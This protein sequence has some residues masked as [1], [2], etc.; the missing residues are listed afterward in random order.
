MTSQDWHLRLQLSRVLLTIGCIAAAVCAQTRGPDTQST[1]LNQGETIQRQLA[2]GQSHEYYFILQAGQYTRLAV[3]QR[4]INVAVAVFASDG[5]E[6]FVTD[7]YGIGAAEPVELIADI[8][9]IYRFR[10][11]ASER[12]APIGRYEL[13]LSEVETATDRHKSRVAATRAVAQAWMFSA[14]QTREGLLK[15]V[16]NLEMGLVNWQAAGDLFEQARTMYSIGLMYTVIGDQQKALDYT[17]RALPVARVSHDARAEAWALDSIGLVY[18]RF[19]DKRKAVEYYD[20]ALLLMRATKDRAGE[21][22]TLNHLGAAYLR[23]GEK[24]KGLGCFEQAM[25]IFRELQDRFR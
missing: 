14:S 11:S 2:G 12:R 19:G 18:D 5:K 1:L 9:G 20:Q 13:N 15:A 23:L 10:V 25:P 22:T 8:T 21:G 17:T 24:R 16:D 3:E 7:G 6:A 4:T